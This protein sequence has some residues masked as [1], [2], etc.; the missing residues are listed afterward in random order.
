MKNFLKY[1]LAFTCFMLFF[2]CSSDDNDTSKPQ[3]R[4]TRYVSSYPKKDEKWLY[5]DKKRLIEIVE[6]KIKT[7]FTYDQYDRVAKAMKYSIPF[8]ENAYDSTFFHYNDE[9]IVIEHGWS[10]TKYVLNN[11]GQPIQEFRKGLGP[12]YSLQKEFTYQDGNMI[13]VKIADVKY[14]FTYDNKKNILADYPV[15]I[16][17][18][19]YERYMN[20]LGFIS[21]NNIISG[22]FY[23]GET[24]FETI[25]Y[26]L[27]YD[28]DG[29][30]VK[31]ESIAGYEI[32]SY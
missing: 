25:P 26:Q 30:I 4:I 6:S 9:E 23:G 16:R 32:V 11:E 7:I 1:F 12:S 18:L 5:D 13:K 20:S 22:K 31:S 21:K 14:E 28:N 27:T 2:G 19:A 24:L 29:Y 15:G 3:K 17:L 8:P 10:K